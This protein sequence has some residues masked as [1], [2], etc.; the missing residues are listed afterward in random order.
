MTR[1]LPLSEVKINLS[2]LIADVVR[3]EDE[4]V[5]T[6]HGRPAAVLLSSDEYEGWKETQ[7]IKRDKD[8]MRQIKRSLSTPRRKKR[9]YT[10]DE[11]DEL[12]NQPSS[13]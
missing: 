2:R 8:L 3:R 1:T 11:L 9:L 13:K 5:I 10:V 7:E 6:R 4:I 12:F